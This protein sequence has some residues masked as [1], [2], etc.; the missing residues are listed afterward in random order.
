M[1]PLPLPHTATQ[2]EEA[3]RRLLEEEGRSKAVRQRYSYWLTCKNHLVL[4][5][6]HGS[7]TGK[8]VPQ[9]SEGIHFPMVFSLINVILAVHDVSIEILL[10][11]FRIKG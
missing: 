5:N 10:V 7:L 8:G 2:L 6:L 1:P 9:C 3:R 11:A 4:I